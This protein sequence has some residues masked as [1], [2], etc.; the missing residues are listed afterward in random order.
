MSTETIAFATIV[1]GAIGVPLVNGIKKLC[2][3]TGYKLQAKEAL[4][5]TVAVAVILGAV[6]LALTGAFNKPMTIDMVGGVIGGVFTVATVVYK[7][8]ASTPDPS[9]QDRLKN[10]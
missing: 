6:V 8:L 3:M 7:V 4:L 2:E 10:L 5:V 9:V 1:A